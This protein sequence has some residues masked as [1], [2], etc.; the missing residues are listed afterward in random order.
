MS[1][2]TTETEKDKRLAILER[3]LVRQRG[4]LVELRDRVTALR[5]ENE[6]LTGDLDYTN[7]CWQ[8]CAGQL[9]QAREKNH[10]L[11]DQLVALEV[12]GN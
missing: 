6:T 11:W 8:E 1:E 12:G 4:W 7:K 10:R 2:S 3:T 9:R 5:E